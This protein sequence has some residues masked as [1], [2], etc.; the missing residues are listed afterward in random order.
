MLKLWPYL[1]AGIGMKFS[2]GVAEEIEKQ[3][4]VIIT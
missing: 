3:M 4:G 1:L 2:K